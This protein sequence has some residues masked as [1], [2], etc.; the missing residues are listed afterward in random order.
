[1]T[2]LIESLLEFSRPR[3]SM[4]L[5]WVRLDEVLDHALQIVRA[6]PEFRSKTIMAGAVRIEGW[7]D[8]NKLQRV[9]QNLIIN[10]C[11][12]TPPEGA[13]ITVSAGSR[14]R[15][16]EIRVADNGRGIP[17]GIRDR[18][19][20]PFVSYGKENCTGLG[21]TIVQ[22]IVQDHGGEVAVRETSP[23]GT[24]IVVSL[25]LATSGS[26]LGENLSAVGTDA[27]VNA[28]E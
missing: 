9:V 10:A 7:F 21:L 4:R 28:V 2:D 27:R 6:R 24:V 18:I 19:F 8:A 17:D 5:S 25:P 23:A 13:M 22:K 20:E 12:A 11:E 26:P 15:I 16:V 14:D 3:E 1:M